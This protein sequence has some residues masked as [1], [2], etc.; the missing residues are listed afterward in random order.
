M[1]PR[2]DPDRRPRPLGS[3]TI[4]GLLITLSAGTGFATPLAAQVPADPLREKRDSSGY[5]LPEVT[6]QARQSTGAFATPLAV[7][8][9]APTDAFGQPATGWTT[10]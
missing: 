7:T 4:A 10:R 2:L 1:E 8:T 5:V 6:V 3:D 9:V